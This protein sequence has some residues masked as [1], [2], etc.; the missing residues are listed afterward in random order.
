LNHSPGG[1]SKE[2]IVL[3]SPS[4]V[5]QESAKSTPNRTSTQPLADAKAKLKAS[6]RRKK[7]V[8]EVQNS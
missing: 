7:T 3:D 6:N 8:T 4:K 2:K 1:N 5:S